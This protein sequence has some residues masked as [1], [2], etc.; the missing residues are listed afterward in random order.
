MKKYDYWCTHAH[1]YIYCI[2]VCQNII[3]E[4]RVYSPVC[5]FNS[6]KLGLLARTISVFL[7]W[8]WCSWQC[9]P[10]CW[11]DMPNLDFRLKLESSKP[12]SSISSFHSISSKLWYLRSCFFIQRLGFSHLARKSIISTCPG[13]VRLGEKFQS[14]VPWKKKKIRWKSKVDP[15]SVNPD[16]KGLLVALEVHFL[17]K[18]L[19]L[20]RN[21]MELHNVFPR[22]ENE[23]PTL[24]RVGG[25]FA[26]R[27]SK[28]SRP[29][30]N[31]G[32]K[33]NQPSQPVFPTST[34][35]SSLTASFSA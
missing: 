19:S 2:Y 27:V 8:H 12:K 21:F 32:S 28:F 11:Q 30:R 18:E 34:F 17:A 35:C 7:Q 20:T 31:L 5:P 23:S 1:V 6:F 15:K 29:G 13:A 9:L 26:Q 33:S 4:S 3:Q 10:K 14:S 22:S 25:C 24:P 16:T